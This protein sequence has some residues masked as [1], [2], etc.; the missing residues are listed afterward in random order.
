MRIYGC[1]EGSER[2]VSPTVAKILKQEFEMGLTNIEIYNNFQDRAQKVKN[3]LIKFLIEQK[4]L[5]KSVAGYGAAAKGNTIL[6]YAG[7][8]PDLLPYICDS[9]TSKQ[10]HFMPGSNIPILSPEVIKEKKPDYILILPWNLSSEIIKAYS[11]V[12]DWGA[13]FVTAVPE[14]KIIQ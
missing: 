6:N 12:R 1:L 8:K 11:F 9:A 4:D 13:K 10:G 2:T 14:I 5:G 7:I 3:A